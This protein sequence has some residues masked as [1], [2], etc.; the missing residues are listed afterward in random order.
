M[1]SLLQTIWRHHLDWVE[2]P[3]TASNHRV[4]FQWMKPRTCWRKSIWNPVNWIFGTSWITARDGSIGHNVVFKAFYWLSAEEWWAQNTW[5]A[6]ENHDPL[7]FKWMSW[8]ISQVSWLMSCMYPDIAICHA[9]GRI[10]F[11]LTLHRGLSRNFFGITE[12]FQETFGL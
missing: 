7:E 5:V 3:Q 6:S 9:H 2:K 11:L 4:A 10:F 8:V 1:F 12:D